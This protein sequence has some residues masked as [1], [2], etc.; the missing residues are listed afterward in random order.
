MNNAEYQKALNWFLARVPLSEDELELIEARAAEIAWLVA[1]N[2]QL[3]LCQAVLDQI[4]EAQ[5]SG[6]AFEQFKE[7]LL[8]WFP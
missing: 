5:S 3:R 6:V 2:M 7:G 1:Q 4:T 8:E